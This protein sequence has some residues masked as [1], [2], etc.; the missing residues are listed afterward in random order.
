MFTLT[1]ACLTPFSVIAICPI[2]L[3]VTNGTVMVNRSSVD[4]TATFFCAPGYELVGDAIL[5]CGN[6]RKWNS[7]LPV[8]TPYISPPVHLSSSTKSTEQSSSNYQFAHM[9]IHTSIH[10]MISQSIHP[11]IHSSGRTSIKNHI[12]QNNKTEISGEGIIV[13]CTTIS[14]VIAMAG[15]LLTFIFIFL[16]YKR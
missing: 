2:P 13:I 14:A 1:P 3:N 6:D 5:T 4:N 9:S 10:L 16:F 12:Q 11:S 8:C 7:D 15:I